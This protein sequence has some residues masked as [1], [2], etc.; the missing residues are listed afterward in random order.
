MAAAATI[1]LRGD[2]RLAPLTEAFGPHPLQT[3]DVFHDPT[4]S[5]DADRLWVVLVSF[6]IYPPLSTCASDCLCAS[7]LVPVLF[8]ALFQ[9]GCCTVLTG[10]LAGW[11][12]FGGD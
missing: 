6:S 7:D 8:L 9:T 10:P 5:P 12:I 1:E 11:M 4:V 3:V 2:I